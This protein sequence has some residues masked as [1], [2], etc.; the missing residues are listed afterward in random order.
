MRRWSPIVLLIALA[1]VFSMLYMGSQQWAY[2]YAHSSTHA[3]VLSSQSSTNTTADN[4]SMAVQAIQN[5]APSAPYIYSALKQ[6]NG[7]VLARTPEGNHGQPVGNAITLA[8]F[9]DQFGLSES[10]SITTMQLSPDGR[11][12]AINGARDHGEQVWIFDTQQLRLSLTPANVLGNFLN[13]MPAGNGHTF[14]YRPMFPQGPNAPLNNGVWNP[15][16]WEINAASGTFTNI[17]IS[18]PS[19]FLVD[20]AASP[21]GTRIIYSTSTGLG[22]GS[23]TWL[24]NSN[25]SN[26][27][28]LFATPGN[29]QAI[30]AMFA[31]S[32]DGKFVAFQMLADSPTPFLPASL[33][34]MNTQGSGQRMIAQTDGGHGYKLA[35]SPDS[36]KIAYIV[37]TNVS[38]SSANQQ[39]QA[40]QCAVA[41]VDVATGHSELVASPGETGMQL[42]YAPAWSANSS[43]IT[44]IASN[45]ANKLLGGSPRYWSASLNNSQMRPSLAPLTPAI[46]HIVALG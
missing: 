30:A 38:D 41:V 9:G 29:G 7:F 28:H 24:M 8:S 6:T 20:A 2:S 17:D 39:A 45:P 25:G 16:L 13:W 40:L 44:F 46:P 4:K 21:D 11:Y 33:W 12:L 15:G 23:D 1:A 43:S 10:D 32:P 31:W 22:L 36:S 26:I 19:A 35:W 42:N 34:I 27:H 5:V 3:H 37:R 14:L 18:M